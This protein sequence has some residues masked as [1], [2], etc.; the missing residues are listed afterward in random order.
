MEKR[1]ICP[2]PRVWQRIYGQ[3]E[4]AHKQADD[5][6]I[7]PPPSP[8]DMNIWLFSSDLEKELRWTETQEWAERHGFSD[9]LPAL[10]EDEGYL[11]YG[12]GDPGGNP[13]GGGFF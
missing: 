1:A 7:P 12:E 2:Q 9:V 3:L 13:P 6:S 5:H 11:G 10:A 4:A 8:P